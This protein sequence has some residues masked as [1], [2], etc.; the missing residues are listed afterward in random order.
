MNILLLS[1][2]YPSDDLPSIYTPVAHYFAKEWVKQGHSV[3]VCNSFSVFPKI[4][5]K[6]ASLIGIERVS[7]FFGFTVVS[8]IVED[9]RYHIDGVDVARFTMSKFVPHRRFLKSQILSQVSKIMSFCEESDFYPDIIV[10]HWL[11]PQIELLVELSKKF[12]NAKTALTLH[13]DLSTV[14]RLYAQ[15]IDVLF[16]SIDKIGFRNACAQREFLSDFPTLKGKTY[17]SLSGIPDMF[18]DGV[19]EHTFSDNISNY[20]FVGT[21]FSRKYPEAL[22]QA[23]LALEN[24]DFSISY[25]GD[26]EQRKVIEQLISEKQLETNVRL[27]GKIPRA[28]I[29][30]HLEN[31]D[32]LIMISRN[33]VYGLVYLE[34][35]ALGCIVVASKNEGFDGIIVDGE[36]GFLCEAGNVEELSRIMLHMRSLPKQEIQRISKKAM[37]TAKDMTDSKCAQ[38]YLQN[39]S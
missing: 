7:S 6:I 37:E 19:C 2:I 17:L 32:S 18:L 35:M 30:N 33:E 8:N 12:P 27:L 24:K 29:R 9:K 28:E 34:A 13:D 16:A 36:N 15:Q 10:G 38:A 23:A 21:L 20:V 1:S 14:K 4:Y 25:I 22:L 26:G 31:S 5:Y 11:N 39:I 3:K